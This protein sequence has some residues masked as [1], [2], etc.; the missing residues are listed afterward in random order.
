MLLL[1]EFGDLVRSPVRFDASR[2]DF[3]LNVLLFFDAIEYAFA[4]FP[5]LD[6]LLGLVMAAL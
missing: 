5:F 2:V 6:P 3:G 4:L 1:P